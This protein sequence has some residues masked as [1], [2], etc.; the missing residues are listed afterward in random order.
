VHLVG[1]SLG[2]PR[3]G[4]YSAQNPRKVDRLVLL[5]P[6]YNRNVAAEPPTEADTR[7]AMGAQSRTDFFNTWNAPQNCSGQRET[8]VGETIFAEMLASDP[9]GATWGPGIRRAPN[10]TNWGW[11][12]PVVGRSTTPLLAIAAAN[13]AS[14]DPERVRELFADYGADEKILIDLGCAS[15]SPMWEGVHGILFAATL[16]W[17]RSGTVNGESTG[18]VRLGYEAE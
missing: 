1:W 6:A 8:A 18:V 12:P 7:P 14:V 10:V 5:A 11:G 17:L 4:G 9:V 16:E 3:A 2:G 13:D 15:H